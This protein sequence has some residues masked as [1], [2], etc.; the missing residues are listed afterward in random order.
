VILPAGQKIQAYNTKGIKLALTLMAD[1]SSPYW[2]TTASVPTNDGQSVLVCC[3]NHPEWQGTP[4]ALAIIMEEGTA[5][6]NH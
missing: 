1:E 6:I 2:R 5:K 4:F 3:R